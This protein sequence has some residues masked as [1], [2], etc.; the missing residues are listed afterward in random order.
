MSTSRGTL[1]ATPADKD[2][3]MQ[4]RTLCWLG[5][6]DR[7]QCRHL[8]ACTPSVLGRHKCAQTAAGTPPPH[9]ARAPPVLV[10]HVRPQLRN[11]QWV[12][13]GH[14]KARWGAQSEHSAG[15]CG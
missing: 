6:P 7:T 3:R 1:R 8:P 12:L 2:A 10:G 14:S 9:S 11:L 4:S 13:G 5:T 15:C